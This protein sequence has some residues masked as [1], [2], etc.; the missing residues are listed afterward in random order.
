MAYLRYLFY[1]Q[2][3]AVGSYMGKSRV[4]VASQAKIHV[5][6]GAAHIQCAKSRHWMRNDLEKEKTV[7][8]WGMEQQR[9]EMRTNLWRKE[10]RN[11]HRR[12]TDLWGESPP[13][14]ILYTRG[15]THG[16]WYGQQWF[17]GVRIKAEI[18]QEKLWQRYR[19][20]RR[21]QRTDIRTRKI[22]LIFRVGKTKELMFICCCD[23]LGLVTFWT[24]K[25]GAS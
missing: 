15:K 6:K 2:K 10:R 14:Q 9:T 11:K 13:H 20:I 8:G 4:Y 7:Q 17:L 23:R 12:A 16:C 21:G 22:F 19:G 1:L 3:C 5:Y 25:L 24:V 18:G